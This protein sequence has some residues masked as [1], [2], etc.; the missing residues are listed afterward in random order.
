MY[1][2]DD[3]E[4]KF[5]KLSFKQKYMNTSCSGYSREIRSISILST[6]CAA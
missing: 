6:R 5:R 1:K 2:V 3:L 4:K